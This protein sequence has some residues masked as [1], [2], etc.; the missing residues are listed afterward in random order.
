MIYTLLNIGVVVTAFIWAHGQ[1]D[2]ARAPKMAWAVVF[3]LIISLVA[4]HGGRL[5]AFKNR[6]ALI[7]VAFAFL[8]Y[9]LTPCPDLKMFGIESGRFWSWEPIFYIVIFML[10]MVTVSSL[11]FSQKQLNNLLDTMMYCGLAIEILVS[12]QSVHLDQFFEHRFGTYGHM[13]GTL[14][15]P[16]LIGPYLG[17]IIPITL[18]RRK[19]WMAAVMVYATIA[20][21]SNVAIG[22]LCMAGLFFIATKSKKWLITTAIATLLIGGVVVCLYATTPRFRE[23]CPDNQRF[24]TWTQAITDLNSPPMKDSKK[25]YVMTGLGAGSFM[26]LFHA[27][28]N[29]RPGE[30]MF[31]YAHNDFVQVLYEFGI[32][33]LFIFLMSIWYVFKKEFSRVMTMY[34]RVLLTSMFWLLVSALGIFSLQIGTTLFYGIIIAGL[35]QNEGTNA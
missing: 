18:F 27:K 17:I 25:K 10:F 4:I 35:L 11:K 12:L 1:A 16:T 8:A 3:A 13:A 6:W 14:G 32:F 7:M 28:N 20:T 26:Y 24:T 34:R 29:I 23:V 15:N 2:P 19:W 33:G 5:K 21:S 30:S 9:Y 22:S 31:V